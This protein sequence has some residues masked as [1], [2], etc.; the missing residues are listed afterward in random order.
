MKASAGE[1]S[2][3]T[4]GSGYESANELAQEILRGV[5]RIH[6]GSAENVVFG[7]AVVQVEYCER[8]RLQGKA[9]PA[10]SLIVVSTESP[11]HTLGGSTRKFA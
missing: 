1:R 3:S 2:T 5:S 7:C 6:C 9:E 8:V 11:D 10:G 4:Y